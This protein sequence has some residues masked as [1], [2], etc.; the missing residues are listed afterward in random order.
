M[1]LFGKKKH[2]HVLPCKITD[3]NDDDDNDNDD[4]FLTF[5]AQDEHLKLC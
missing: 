1:N 3:D 2:I 5:V 4:T